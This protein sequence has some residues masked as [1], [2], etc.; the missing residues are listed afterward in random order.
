MAYVIF[1]INVICHQCVIAQSDQGGVQGGDGDPL[2]KNTV[3][4]DP[5][6]DTLDPWKKMGFGIGIGFVADVSGRDRVASAELTGDPMN[7]IVR[8]TDEEN[9]TPRL[10]FEIHNFKYKLKKDGNWVHGP[11]FAVQAGEKE[12]IEAVS[13]GWM[14]GL[15]YLDQS[16]SF[17]I[18]IG[19]SADP[20]AQTLGDGIK[21]NKPLPA[22]E[23]EIRFKEETQFGLM[24]IF[25]T[26]L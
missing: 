13:L 9:E 11:Y 18:G 7:P 25:S 2:E 26:T 4:R 21:A 15:P 6:G 10:I 17:N 20:N 12:I 22:G 24:I 8:V 14:F 19:I 16:R 3:P 1:F 23:T 5:N